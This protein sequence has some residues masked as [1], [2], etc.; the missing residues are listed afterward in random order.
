ML[1]QPVHPES[2]IMHCH[3]FFSARWSSLGFFFKAGLR[4]RMSNFTVIFAPSLR[5]VAVSRPILVNCYW[6]YFG[7]CSANQCT[8]NPILLS[9]SSFH[10]VVCFFLITCFRDRTANFQIIFAS[11]LGGFVGSRPSLT[12]WYLTDFQGYSA[13]QCTQIKYKAFSEFFSVWWPSL[14]FS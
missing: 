14:V 13:N 6:I 8:Q 3:S 12:N 9:F 4:V 2:N 5:S 1:C 7:A 11:S 10:G